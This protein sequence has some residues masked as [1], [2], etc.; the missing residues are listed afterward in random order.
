MSDKLGSMLFRGGC[1][2]CPKVGRTD[3]NGL[4]MLRD[5]AGFY[6]KQCRQENKAFT[7][8]RKQLKDSDG[9]R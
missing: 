4:R 6:C 7:E 8:M 1:T 3:E 2:R 5:T 9:N